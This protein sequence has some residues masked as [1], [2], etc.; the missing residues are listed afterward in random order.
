[1]L[2]ATLTPFYLISSHLLTELTRCSSIQCQVQRCNS[3]RRSQKIQYIY[4]DPRSSQMYKRKIRVWRETH[5]WNQWI[6]DRPLNMMLLNAGR[7]YLIIL[8]IRDS[9]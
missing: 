1:L 2:A 6:A 7:D 9:G 3:I 5:D 4:V 8:S